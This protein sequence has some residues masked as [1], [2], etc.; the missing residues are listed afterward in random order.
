MKR[1]EGRIVANREK[2]STA[3][4][5]QRL[6]NGN[7][8]ELGERKSDGS[9]AALDVIGLAVPVHPTYVGN[10]GVWPRQGGH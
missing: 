2:R 8:K 3:L 7:E 4:Q 9:R 5:Q 1:G 6:L 10:D